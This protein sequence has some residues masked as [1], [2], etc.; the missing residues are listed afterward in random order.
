[1]KSK[2]NRIEP[3]IVLN[4]LIGLIGFFSWFDFFSYFFGFLGLI[5]FSV[6]LVNY[7]G[8]SRRHSATTEALV[9]PPDKVLCWR[10]F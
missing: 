6:F 5:C 7:Y 10:R 3:N 4:I 8:L 2:S 1:M 9:M